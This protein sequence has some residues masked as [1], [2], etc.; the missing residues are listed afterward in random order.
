M[1]TK[2]IDR[3][4]AETL[5]DYRL[6]RGE[7]AALRQV[8]AET[9]L[10]DRQRA[11]VRHRVFAQ[12]QEAIAG[13]TE[14]QILAWVENTLKA[15]QASAGDRGSRADVYFSPG[16][17]CLNALIRALDEVTKTVDICVF[18]ITD[19]RVSRR[20]LAAHSRG[21][22]VRIITDDDKSED[23][24]S[25][26]DDL[27]RQGIAVRCDNSPHHMH[28]KFAVFDRTTVATGSYNWTRSAAEHNREN[29]LISDDARIVAPY[30][31]AFDELWAEL[32]VR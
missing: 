1:D 7:R 13:R 21:V 17:D 4:L 18:T 11:F 19:N 15:L 20:I 16:E 9:Q 24:G 2:E 32:D 22:T 10:D 3:L 5:E 23:R 14:Q 30:L 27:A 26:V 29:L 25:D 31:R 28:H 6:S 8:F 12:A